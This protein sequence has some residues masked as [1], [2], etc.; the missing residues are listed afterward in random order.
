MAAGGWPSTTQGAGYPAL[1]ETATNKQNFQFLDFDDTSGQ[2][3]AE[4][5]AEWTFKVPC[6]ISLTNMTANFTWTTSGV[7][8]TNSVVWAIQA[9][10]Y[11]DS[12]ALDGAWSTAVT[13]TDANNTTSFR[14]NISANTST[15][16]PANYTAGSG[17]L[18]QFRVYRDVDNGSDNLAATAK[19]I[20]VTLNVSQGT[21]S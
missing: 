11:I 12:N 19:L 6:N 7:L 10:T 17:S 20:C 16:T 5:Y 14:T 8:T 13:V 1:Y 2:D 15:F 21:C 4:R 9:R 3:P 18:A